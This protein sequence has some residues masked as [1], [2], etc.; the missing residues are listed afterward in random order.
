MSELENKQKTNIKPGIKAIWRH[1]S[2]F[3]REVNWLII[4]GL[5]SA[6]SNGFVPYAT[7]RF[8][9]ALIDVSNHKD[10]V[11]YGWM[12]LWALFISI[13]TI[14][15][16]VANN[17]DWVKDRLRRKVNSKIQ[18][19]VQTDGFIHLFQLPISYH[20]NAHTNGE[21]Q[22]ISM[23]SW[24]MAAIIGKVVD[25]AP[26]LLSIMIGL[27]LAAS[28][29]IYLASVL[30]LG[31]II[32][33]AILINIVRPMAKIDSEMHKVWNQSWDDAAASVQQ[34]ESVKQANAERYEIE[35]VQE[36][37][38]VRSQNLWLKIA[39]NWGSIEF[40]QRSIVFVTQLTVFLISVS[41]VAKGSITIGQLIALNG[42]SLMF[43]GPFASL[44]SSWEVIQNGITSAAHVEGIFNQKQEDYSP[45]DAV[46]LGKMQG[47]V[48]FKGVHFRYGPGQPEVLAGIDLE[49][50][51]G[52][53]I[54]LVGESGVGKSTSISLI[55][56]YHF[57]TEGSVLVDGIDTRKLDLN[58]L[59]SQIAVVAQEVAL[60]N[61]S[62]KTN[63]RYGTFNASDEEV[64]RVA[65]EAHIDD[66][67]SALPDK[68][69]TLVGERGIKLSVG[70]KQ[71]VAIARAM[72]RDPAIL[73]LDEPTSALD[74]VTEKIVTEGLERLM[75]N[76]T[77]F[78]IAHRLS[79][80]RRADM[81]LV[82]E[83]GRVVESGPH[84][85]LIAKEGGVY[86]K[87]YEYQIGLH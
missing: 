35:K 76:R 39:N 61:D 4:L 40:L 15:Q 56:G 10:A 41:L 77:T 47:R 66:F 82:F 83:K 48:E 64:M 57:P 60:F 44:G 42:Y 54:A 26:Q 21:L 55:S 74:A 37:L 58:E 31:V 43:F 36:S 70:Q 33:S 22:T 38:L 79:T 50:H 17:I 52:Q 27:A 5:V 87:L 72:L 63:I 19:K 65:K 11:V 16:L 24:R 73:I 20:K 25:I 2:S 30:L 67:V 49:I 45:K 18:F 75:H 23:A 13:W 69:D 53:K 34:I 1:L 78:I 7:G 84:K 32:Y 81:I 86:K 71:R 68:Y 6:I 59:R 12:P 80:V 14:T 9:D 8:F 46:A 85:E 3:R 51:P 29:N 28:I 62:I